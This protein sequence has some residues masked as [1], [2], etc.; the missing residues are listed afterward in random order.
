MALQKS[1]LETAL[2]KGF[3]V[4]ALATHDAVDPALRDVGFGF[5]P[6]F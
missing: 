1:T 4:P 2:A 6:K 5:K 3:L